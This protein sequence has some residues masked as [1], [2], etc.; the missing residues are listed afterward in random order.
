MLTDDFEKWQ[1]CIFNK[2]CLGEARR[3]QM[4][5]KQ[6]MQ[7]RKEKEKDWKH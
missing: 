3:S 1:D 7:K 6:I 4:D 5:S 2:N